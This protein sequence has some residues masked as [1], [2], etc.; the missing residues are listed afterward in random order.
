[1]NFEFQ[2]KREF[3]V[4]DL[5][6]AISRILGEGL[7]RSMAT[8]GRSLSR[9]TLIRLCEQRVF[10]EGYT[11]DQIPDLQIIWSAVHNIKIKGV[12]RDKND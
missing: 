2:T 11:E 6:S 1:M 10:L 4:E 9:T 8:S 12:L 3:T 7:C 5:D